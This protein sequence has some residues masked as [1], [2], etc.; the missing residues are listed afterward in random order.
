MNNQKDNNKLYFFIESVEKRI[1]IEINRVSQLYKK[2]RI[3]NQMAHE[4]LHQG[5]RDISE[6]IS[7][8]HEKI[9]FMYQVKKSMSQ[10]LPGKKYFSA[11][12]YNL[13]SKARILAYLIFHFKKHK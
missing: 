10:K 2:D 1:Q 6:M 4:I 9:N 11:L 5:S 8:E 7:R 12:F 13:L 3:S